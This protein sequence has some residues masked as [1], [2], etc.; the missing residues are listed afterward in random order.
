[1]SRKV[2]DYWCYATKHHLTL[3]FSSY[4]Y[5][6]INAM[7][8]VKTLIEAYTK[9]IFD[10]TWQPA[11]LT[12]CFVIAGFAVLYCFGLAQAGADLDSDLPPPVSSLS[13]S[14]RLL[15]SRWQFV[16]RNVPKLLICFTIWAISVIS[17]C[18]SEHWY[19]SV[20]AIGFILAATIILY[21]YRAYNENRERHIQKHN[22]RP[23]P[24]PSPPPSP[25]PSRPATTA[26]PQNLRRYFS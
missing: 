16:L 18:K 14:W 7:S 22:R 2:R 9:G 24:P 3:Q 23:S 5:N 1:M 8:S 10:I 26:S 25:L 15:N 6:A 20:I 19:D 21:W 11:W 4:L 13:A 17:I 12:I